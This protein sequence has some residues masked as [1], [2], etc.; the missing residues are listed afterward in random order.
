MNP[1]YP[2]ALPYV[3]DESVTTRLLGIIFTNEDDTLR[4]KFDI[5]HGKCS[6]ISHTET[7]TNNPAEGPLR[8]A[9][10][11]SEEFPLLLSIPAEYNKLK[12]VLDVGLVDV[13]S[14]QGKSLTIHKTHGKDT[15]SSQPKD[16]SSLESDSLDV[17]KIAFSKLVLDDKALCVIVNDTIDPSKF[18][19]S[20]MTVSL[21]EHSQSDVSFMSSFQ[22]WIDSPLERAISTA[23]VRES[24]SEQQ[25]SISGEDLSLLELRKA[26]NFNIED[27]PEFRKMLR[28]YERNL[29][30]LR[31]ATHSLLDEVKFLETTLRR[32]R[33]CRKTVG[34]CL[35]S[36]MD[37]QFNPLLG[38]LNVH[39]SFS[40]N[41]DLLFDSVEE[42]INFVVK[43]V[44]SPNLISKMATYFLSVTSGDGHD[45][46]H[47]KKAFEKQSK[48]FYDWLNKYL[49]N[50]KDRPE[51]KLLLK[52]K[53]FYLSSFDYL[54][55]LNLASNNQYFNQF[56]ENLLLFSNL[57]SEQA[58][59]FKLSKVSKQVL[60]SE[61]AR[62]Y[63]NSLSRFN[64]EKMQLRQMIETCRTNEELT[65]LIQVN[66]LNPSKSD[67]NN[68]TTFDVPQVK[69]DMVF[70]ASAA[71]SSPKTNLNYGNTSPASGDIGD[72]NADLSGI[73]YARG[74]QGKQG[75]HKEWVVLRKGQLQEYSDWRQGTLPINKPID[76]ALASVK[77]VTKDKRQFCFEILTSL[78]HK[79]VFQAI[80]EEERKKWM[81]TLYNAG[82]V[83]LRLM[84][85]RSNKRTPEIHT[86][87][88]SKMLSA[89]DDRLGSPVS[90]VSNSLSKMDEENFIHV[91]RSAENSGNNVCA[92]CGSTEGVEWV[93]S[94]FL[95]TI[96][97]SCSSCHR[98]MGSH[99]SRV[100]SLKL[101]N[102]KAENRILLGYVNNVLVNTYLEANVPLKLTPDTTYEEKLQYAKQKYEEKEFLQ[103]MKN[104]TASLVKAVQAID[105]PEVIHCINSGADVNINLQVSRAQHAGHITVTLFEYSLRK[106]VE[107]EEGDHKAEY[108]VISELLLLNGCAIKNIE[109]HP[110]MFA[111]DKA[112]AYFQEKKDKMNGI[113]L[114]KP[115]GRK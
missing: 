55:S 97:V 34:D 70:P 11:S 106:I 53:H 45:G 6:N 75:W 44:L 23:P 85:N 88:D 79:H 105:I 37:A 62:L 41:F 99:I 32:L 35:E 96:C 54:N 56:L 67:P 21:W 100:R 115:P 92:D 27:G 19:N 93:S 76:V 43:D 4:F 50:E 48:E 47:G 82:Q 59:S 83:T 31:R 38:R 61:D 89:P 90:I 94:N 29:P 74:G 28:A 114:T 69:I 77:P 95:V 1:V 10:N 57:P 102:F 111:S 42:T 20:K 33:S 65:N 26:F 39:E 58:K 17:S 30:K 8:Y 15:I 78:G 24:I 7:R 107:V 104:P 3:E 36:I 101:D 16:Y 84:N 14:N 103:P 22:V 64:S 108:F 51:L 110:E 66:P 71:S 98:N 52:R 2:L 87:I 40:L 73:L 5:E 13:S 12:I 81:R 49:S 68:S 72:Q 113:S 91:V 112:V 25:N 63:I 86:T 60:L 80:N 9:S 109:L 46:S 18:H